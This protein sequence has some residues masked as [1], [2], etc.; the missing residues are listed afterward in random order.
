MEQKYTDD[1]FLA[2]WLNKD[3]NEEERIAFEKT[4]EYK[5]Y[6]KIVEKME[7]FQAPS[8]NKEET[9]KKIK[10]KIK[11][12]Q[13]VKN[14]RPNWVYSIAASIAL[15]IGMFYFV[16]LDTVYK[17]SYGEQLAVVLPDGSEVLLNAKSKIYFDEKDW[18]KGIRNLTLNGEGYFKVKKGSKFT[19]ETE[20]GSVSVLGTQFN[21]KRTQGY[22]EVKCF[23]GSVRLKNASDEVILTSGRGYQKIKGAAGKNTVFETVSPSW[24]SGESSFVETPLAYVIKELE[25]QYKVSIET[26]SVNISQLFTGSF[27]NNNRDVALKSVF[28]PLQIL[29]TIDESDK[30]ILSEK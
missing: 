28:I 6:A 24:I 19:V 1:T 29:V 10:N 23:E 16:G 8:F 21:V 27:S 14:L 3:L 25:K 20:L 9:F 4:E 17:T 2:R 12:Q 22:F 15:L 26:D 5:G 30:L 7:L 11:P 13:K 18:E